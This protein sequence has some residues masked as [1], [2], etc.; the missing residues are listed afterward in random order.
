MII[1]KKDGE[2][3][4]QVL[5][6]T[7]V[8]SQVLHRKNDDNHHARGLRDVISDNRACIM[9]PIRQEILSGIRQKQHFQVLREHLSAFPDL[10]IKT[11]DYETAAEFS[12][13]LRSKGVQGSAIDF[14]I[15]AV[16]VRYSLQIY[17]VDEDF[18]HF[19]KYL[20]IKLYV[21]Q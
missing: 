20:P 1:K 2:N 18:K 9:G 16:A 19:S 11:I 4:M 15:C 12:N 6:D 17:T 5:V 21:P 8:W 13:L 7:C 10:L 14:L 3:K